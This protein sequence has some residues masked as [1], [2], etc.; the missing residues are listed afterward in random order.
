MFIGVNLTFFPQHFLGLAGMPRR[1]S[2]IYL[3]TILVICTIMII[4]TF[5][6]LCYCFYFSSGDI[7]RPSLLPYGIH[8]HEWVATH[9]SYTPILCWEYVR[10]LGLWF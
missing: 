7:C 6:G 9:G 3:Q 1:Y 4:N 2:D 8:N 5:R 10:G